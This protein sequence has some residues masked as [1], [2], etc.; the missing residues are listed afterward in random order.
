MR[1][2]AWLALLYGVVSCV[3]AVPVQVDTLVEPTDAD[4]D[5]TDILQTPIEKNFENSHSETKS[6]HLE[7]VTA[8]VLSDHHDSHA[9]HD[10]ITVDEEH[11]P[12]AH[13]VHVYSWKFE[14]V[15][16]PLVLCLFV[17]LIG[18]FKIVYHHTPFLSTYL[19]ESCCLILLG[20]VIGC[21][22]LWDNTHESIKFLE[23]DART[24]FLYLLPPIILEAA[25]SLKD[26]A[27]IEN[28]GT[29]ILYA[30]LGTILNIAIIGGALTAL[31]SVGLM[32]GFS[33]GALDCLIFASLIAAV[34]PVAV[35]AIFQEV[36]VNKMLYFMVFGESL[37]NDAVTVVIYNLVIEFKGLSTIAL[38]DVG[39]GCLA[40]LCVSFGGAIIGFAC[41]FISAFITRFTSHVRVVEPVILFGMAYLS[42][43]IAEMF[44]FSG[45][46][47]I[48]C[49]GLNQAQYACLNISPKSY[50]S[51]NYFGKVA[52]SVSESLIFIILGVMM[53]NE[54]GEFWSD[55]DPY[56]SIYSV[57]LCIIARVAVV[58]FLTYIVNH[59]TG[60]VRFISFQEQL[61][62]AYGGLRGA[63]SFSLAFMLS[64]DRVEGHIKNTMLSA[65]YI[66]ILF[67]VF[68]QG[69]TI[70]PLVRFLDIRLAK[71]EDNFKLFMEFNRGMVQHM[72]QGM[73]DILGTKRG[74][75]WIAVT[76]YLSQR[77]MRP[78]LHKNYIRKDKSDKLVQ[79]D[80]DERMREKLKTV[81]SNP[82]MHRQDTL[83]EMVESGEVP[84]H[85]T[86][87]LM[88][89]EEHVPKSKPHGHASKSKPEEI[90]LQSMPHEKVD[91]DVTDIRALVKNPL[92]SY[93][94]DRDLTEDDEAKMKQFE[95]LKEVHRIAKLRDMEKKN[96]VSASS[97]KKTLIGRKSS[98][99]RKDTKQELLI[100][101]LG[102]M[103]ATS[104]SCSPH[105]RV[106][107]ED[108]KD[109][110]KEEKIKF[111]IDGTVV[112]EP[113][114]D[115][116]YLDRE[117]PV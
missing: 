51:V 78:M 58:F 14:Y 111:S 89:E 3:L 113:E 12:H 11:S 41:G 87:D 97:S 47:G 23:Y 53:V 57:L 18:V 100:A 92:Q 75:T 29:I 54:Q 1:A 40:F 102:G 66:V 43:V 71:K 34:D 64:I 112:E 42:F 90:P 26:K 115:D 80:I 117:S 83:T 116:N 28:L 85:L 55:F 56:F 7:A 39:L 96:G 9:S 95:H 72:M 8:A 76:K 110:S 36:G 27:F 48:I 50:I 107:G 13:G 79:L 20:F 82:S 108:E 10:N 104:V 17:V 105:S 52:S 99:K 68:V 24:F 30:V 49:C 62:M 67:T 84:L 37:L 31:G 5:V 45:I 73:E 15:K 16:V 106:K 61:I 4:D 70:K 2:L 86:L 59:F 25:Y 19:P 46:I 21:M 98:T 60:G 88:E 74:T 35:L 101:S 33:M 91:I 69:C 22:F 63:V 6:D 81:P 77:F 114:P 94:H 38:G 93:F 65:T 103:M 32:F 44:H 109:A